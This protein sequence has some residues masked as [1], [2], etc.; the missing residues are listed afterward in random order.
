MEERRGELWGQAV[1]PY[2]VVFALFFYYILHQQRPLKVE[3]KHDS[4]FARHSSGEERAL[5]G[6][7]QPKWASHFTVRNDVRNAAD[8]LISR[9]SRWRLA[10][11]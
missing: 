8:R 11:R 4:Y 3:V 7:K 6:E 1:I 9:A 5:T 10:Q 2:T